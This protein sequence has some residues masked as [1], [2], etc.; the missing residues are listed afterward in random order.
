[1]LKPFIAVQWTLYAWHC[2]A[3][4]HCPAHLHTDDLSISL[5]LSICVILCTTDNEQKLQIL[6]VTFVLSHSRIL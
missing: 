2:P 1:M 3:T 5:Y 4:A 6:Y